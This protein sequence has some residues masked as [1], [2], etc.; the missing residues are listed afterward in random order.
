MIQGN[1]IGGS[2]PGISGSVY[3][4]GDASVPAGQLN[5]IF[6]IRFQASSTSNPI[7]VYGNTIKN[8]Q[9]HTNYSLLASGFLGI[10]VFSGNIEIG[11]DGPTT[12][13]IIGD[14]GLASSIQVTAYNSAGGTRTNGIRILGGITS[15]KIKNNIVGGLSFK[16][17]NSS[18]ST[19]NEVIAIQ[20]LST[21]ANTTCYIDSN[22]I[23]SNSI[24]NSIQNESGSYGAAIVAGVQANPTGSAH[25][26]YIRSNAVKGLYNSYTG[27]STTNNTVGIIAGSAASSAKF[28]IDSNIISNISSLDSNISTG[29]SASVIGIGLSSGTS[30]ADPEIL[31]NTISNMSTGKSNT[32]M[33]GIFYNNTATGAQISRNTIYALS[34]STTTGTITNISGI[35]NFSGNGAT[36]ANNQIS[37]TQNGTSKNNMI[38]ISDNTSANT[39][40]YHYNTVYIGGTQSST[41]VNTSA[42]ATAGSGSTLSLRNNIF[43]NEHTSLGKNNIYTISATWSST[44]SSYN[45]FVTADTSAAFYN[46]GSSTTY[47]FANWKANVSDG[48]GSK[49]NLSSINTSSLFFSNVS[50]GDLHIFS[51][52][53]EVAN[54]GTS[55]ATGNDIDGQTRS[56]SPDIGADEFSATSN[57]DLGI[58]I[59]ATPNT[60]TGLTAAAPVSVYIKNYG[61]SLIPNGSN[62]IL[63]YR[64]NGG[65]P[66]LENTILIGAIAPG[67]SIK[68]TY[69]NLA[70]IS[71]LGTYN[72][73]AWIKG[74]CDADNTNDTAFKT[75]IHQ[76]SIRSTGGD[77]ERSTGCA[78]LSGSSWINLKDNDSNTIM[79]INPNG[80]NL[81][82]TCFGVRIY[83]GSGLRKD[84]ASDGNIGYF[85]DRNFYVTPTIQPT[86]PVSV[87]L[88]VDTADLNEFIDT[89]FNKFAMSISYDS[90][91]INKYHGPRVDLDPYNNDT[92]ISK[93]K[94]I[95]ATVHTWNSSNHYRYFQ[96][97]VNSFSELNPGLV[98]NNPS[99]PLPVTWVNFTGKASKNDAALTWTLANEHNNDYFVIERSIDGVNFVKV[100]QVAS[101]GE[102]NNTV[103]YEYLDIN[104]IALGSE[105]YYRIRQVDFN[106]ASS[107][108]QIAP[109]K[110][111]SNP[112]STVINVWPNPATQNI[113]ITYK[114]ISINENVS[115]KVYDISGKLVMQSAFVTSQTNG[116]AHMAIDNLPYGVYTLRLESASV[117][118]VLRVVKQ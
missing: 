53:C 12:G 48:T 85:L 107:N 17:V 99:Q 108:S 89:V 102:T 117:N 52:Y 7:R 57:G 113:A 64:I 50:M 27:T 11:G 100:G 8:V 30:A 79:S 20:Q 60:G 91:R 86:T 58:A 15:C 26:H 38:G 111:I 70:N 37:L 96:F 114:N 62:Y 29:A 23:G 83:T 110:F 2:I 6:P 87:R 76:D 88:Y 75:V 18:T 80:N 42:F 40:N 115:I 97:N 105:I 98:P 34:N 54:L 72:F 112:Q 28:V 63:G 35:S 44:A 66:V 94:V 93:Y 49:A 109:V 69:T 36:F 45:Y 116:T 55:L 46:S 78:V 77:F 74:L 14:S 3:Q 82:A 33:Y 56:G 16:N 10:L 4:M 19:S 103:T 95:T 43:Y 9:V 25:T 13:N 5:Q 67:D 32:S 101:Y 104:A 81:G 51:N 73:K 41:N 31:R 71:A 1:R 21:A 61:V 106:G 22:V 65:T 47:G 92:A 68:Y 84:T 90:I 118:T 39:Q 24:T 59:I